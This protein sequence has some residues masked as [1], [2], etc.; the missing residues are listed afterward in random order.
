[1]PYAEG[2]R[3]F[4]RG[5]PEETQVS[6]GDYR[7]APSV[8]EDLAAESPGLVIRTWHDLHRTLF[9]A[10]QLEKWCSLIGLNLILLVAVFKIV[11]TL[12]MMVLNKTSEIG[13][14]RVMGLNARQVSEIFRLQGFLV[15]VIG[16]F[17]GT[18]VGLTVYL[19][20][21]TWWWIRLPAA[22]YV[23]PALPMKLHLW[24]VLLIGGTALLIILLAVRYPARRAAEL[25]PIQAIQYKK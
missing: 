9:E 4:Q 21:I 3:L 15:A 18:A 23:I 12:I 25:L 5:A 16:V 22:I 20:Q 6:L 24:E 2:K 14:L 8:A 7:E 17:L 10:M 19:T 11:S 1:M 13:I